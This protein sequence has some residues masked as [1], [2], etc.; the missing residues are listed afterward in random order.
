MKRGT[1]EKRGTKGAQPCNGMKS[2][3]TVK[4]PN[5]RLPTGNQEHLK[6]YKIVENPK[7]EMVREKGLEPPRPKA[8]DPKSGASAIPP[9][10]QAFRGNK[11]RSKDMRLLYTTNSS[12]VNIWRHRAAMWRGTDDAIRNAKAFLKFLFQKICSIFFYRIYCKCNKNIL[13]FLLAL[14]K[15][16]NRGLQLITRIKMDANNYAFR[17]KWP[18]VY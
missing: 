14:K 4:R 5:K 2:Y 18:C 10:S 6:P 16:R 12:S 9:L 1:T 8:P 7:K 3:K 17:L 13:I 11:P 15:Y